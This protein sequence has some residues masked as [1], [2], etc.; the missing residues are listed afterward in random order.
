MRGIP[1]RLL[2]VF[3]GILLA[4]GAA[5]LALAH[6][7]A[8]GHA[9]AST[10]AVK[11]GEFFFR[12]SPKGLSAPQTVTFRFTNIGHV[13]H[14]FKIGGKTSALIQPGKTTMITVALKKGTYPFLCTVPGHAAAGM[15]GV[16]VV[17]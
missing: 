11:G 15:K 2:A 8:S 12:L 16:L 6:A 1:T 13:A 10:I 4:L 9:R 3:G 7:R 14:D 17:G 5:S